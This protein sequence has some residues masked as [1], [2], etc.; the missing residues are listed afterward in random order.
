MEEFICQKKIYKA[1]ITV[2]E[3]GNNN[4][5]IELLLKTLKAEDFISKR[6]KNKEVK[7][8]QRFDQIQLVTILI[9]KLTLQQTLN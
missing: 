2:F 8:I 5:L 4:I 3:C 1:S 7:K 9:K 6:K